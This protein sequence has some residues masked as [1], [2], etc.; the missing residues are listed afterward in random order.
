[1]GMLKVLLTYKQIE[2]LRILQHYV[3]EHG[4]SPTVRELC[5]ITGIKSTSTIKGY[6]DRLVEKGVIE[7]E[8]GKPRT[9]RILKA[10]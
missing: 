4:F 5:Q 9:I 2:F 1:M 7:K 3:K 10:L 8:D 6:I